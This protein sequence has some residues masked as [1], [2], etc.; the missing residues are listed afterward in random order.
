MPA[1]TGSK[2][3]RRR[4]ARLA[5]ILRIRWWPRFLLAGGLLVVIATTLLSGAAEEWV[6]GAGAA[7]I[8]IILV[9]LM[10][11][12]PGDYRHERPVPPGGPEGMQ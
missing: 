11:M 10:S 8:F 6:A 12:S 3:A 5:R 2:P 1:A 9:K 7:I 4:T